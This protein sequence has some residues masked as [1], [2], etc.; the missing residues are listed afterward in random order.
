M[1]EEINRKSA[2]VD[3]LLD[4]SVAYRGRCAVRIER[5]GRDGAVSTHGLRRPQEVQ[6]RLQRRRPSVARKDNTA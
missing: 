2:V 1:P 4:A 5:N 6:M 3:M